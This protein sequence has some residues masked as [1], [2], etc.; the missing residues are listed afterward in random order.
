MGALV[1]P[2]TGRVAAVTEW[3]RAHRAADVAVHASPPSPLGGGT[4]AE[5]RGRTGH[6][7]GDMIEATLALRDIE[8]LAGGA[9]FEAYRHAETGRDLA[10]ITSG[11]WVP[12]DIADAVDT[13]TGF[14]HRS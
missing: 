9:R 1:R 3:L 11:V 13:V 10:R 2:P 6:A 8:Q 5:L 12:D 14:H 7:H 4:G